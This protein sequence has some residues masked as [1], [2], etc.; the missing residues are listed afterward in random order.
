[1]PCLERETDDSHYMAPLVPARRMRRR[2]W[3]AG[4]GD[5]FL[6]AWRVVFDLR[7][8]EVA[9]DTGTVW[10]LWSERR[11]TGLEHREDSWTGLLRSSGP[12]PQAGSCTQQEGLHL[13]LIPW[14]A[15]VPQ[16]SRGPA[17]RHGA[18]GLCC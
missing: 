7:P 2:R 9:G 11:P 6:T 8:R 15:A 3:T 4:Y 13:N 5:S 14:D 10:T 1:M 18:A 12:R 16:D 17:H